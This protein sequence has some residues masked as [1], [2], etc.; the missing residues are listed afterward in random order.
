MVVVK[1]RDMIVGVFRENSGITTNV[2]RRFSDLPQR[3]GNLVDAADCAHKPLARLFYGEMKPETTMCVCLGSHCT[4]TRSAPITHMSPDTHSP[5]LREKVGCYSTVKNSHPITEQILAET[6]TSIHACT[7]RR[8]ATSARK[9]R[10]PTTATQSLNTQD[11]VQPARPG[12]SASA[13]PRAT[14][15][16]GTRQHPPWTNFQIPSTRQQEE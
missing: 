13:K 10:C 15:V 1:A 12:P 9:G 3:F 6:H 4:L 5:K 14:S 2:H 11:T 7:K 8:L 16:G